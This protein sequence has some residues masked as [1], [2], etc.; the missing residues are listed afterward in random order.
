MTGEAVKAADLKPEGSGKPRL[1][2]L[3]RDAMRVRH[4]SY[5][6]EQ[7]YLGW[8]KRFIIFHGK[9]H[10]G[11]LGG[12]DVARF[13][14]WL[15]RDRNVSAATQG[16]A[17]ASILFLYRH[18]LGVDLPWVENIVRARK[19]KHLPVVMTRD[20]VKSPLENMA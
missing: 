10:P 18:V 1:L 8:I 5:R 7:A 11:A 14:S 9:R 3:V 20:E 16:Q 15:A 17:L 13:L 2:D 4:Y 12:E 6:T 19:P